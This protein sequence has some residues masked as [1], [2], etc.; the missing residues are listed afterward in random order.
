M[1][2]RRYASTHVKTVTGRLGSKESIHKPSFLKLSVPHTTKSDKL[3]LRALNF[4]RELIEDEIDIP[5][6][7]MSTLKKGDFTTNIYC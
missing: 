7:V 5:L 2:T 6:P 3:I 1:A 4:L